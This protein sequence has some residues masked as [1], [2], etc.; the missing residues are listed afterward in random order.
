MTITLLADNEKCWIKYKKII[1]NAKQSIL[2][3]IW[4]VFENDYCIDEIEQLLSHKLKQGV[5]VTI[6]Y[7]DNNVQKLEM[8]IGGEDEGLTKTNEFANRMAKRGAKTINFS[9]VDHTRG[10]HRK[11]LVVDNNKCIIG[12][13]NLHKFYY[14]KPIVSNPL[15]HIECDIHIKDS[16][17]VPIISKILL[18][19]QTADVPINHKTYFIQAV[20]IP[21]WT[22]FFLTQPNIIE[23]TYID[24][25]NRAKKSIVLVNCT[26]MYRSRV[27][28]A[29]I[30]ALSR[31]VI[32]VIYANNTN[33]ITYEADPPQL[34]FES[35]LSKP[36]FKLYENISSYL[37]HIKYAIFDEKIIC[38]G[39]FNFDA[40][41]YTK[42]A[43]LLFVQK[44]TILAKKLLINTF[45]IQKK[46][47]IDKKTFDSADE[48]N[49]EFE[50]IKLKTVSI[51]INLMSDIIF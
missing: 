18:A 49:N 20:P 23:D 32:V 36:N 27:K 47:F 14:T 38:I 13:R 45:K 24:L 44:N 7:T 12:S 17:M 6:I 33:Q 39:S 46:Y 19:D 22:D 2:L 34:F 37:L 4:Y 8:I 9:E 5:N 3:V 26:A 10:T 25:I 15:S 11:A 43:E 48:S 30:D 1:S 51:I 28:Q 41:S 42:N 31:G 35:V 40:W 21:K 29:I 50:Q 16:R